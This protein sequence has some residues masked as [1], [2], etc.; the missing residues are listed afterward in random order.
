MLERSEDWNGLC[1]RFIHILAESL[2]VISQE[3]SDLIEACCVDR[4]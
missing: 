2:S 3:H 4:L 1:E